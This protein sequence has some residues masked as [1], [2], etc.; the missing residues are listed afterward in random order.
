M[1]SG[2]L[3]ESIPK[4]FN[5]IRLDEFWK[6][7]CER[8][9]IWERRFVEK[10]KPPWTKDTVLSTQRFT[11][12]Y[13]EL[14]PGTK[15]A[16][17][18]ILEIDAPKADKIF[19]I[20]IYRLIGRSETHK[21]LGFQHLDDFN[22]KSMEKS[23]FDIK[24]RGQPPFTAAYMVS[25]YSMMGSKDKI[26]NVTRIFSRLRDRFPGFY[27]KLINT[28]SSEEAYKIIKE[29]DGFGN[30]LAYQVLV[31]LIYPLR[32]YDNKPILPFSN[33]DWAI[34]G[35]GAR[36][37][38]KLLINAPSKI[39]EL[40]VMRW[41]CQNQSSEFERLGIA[42]PYLK[43]KSGKPVKISLANI[44]N[45]LCEFHKYIKIRDGTGRGRRLFSPSSSI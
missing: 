31:D 4:S 19:N 33:D 12:V 23:L 17:E 8:Q 40:D 36:K 2:P 5:K 16:I 37:G 11:N 29:N 42:F 15:Y 22:P 27:K 34:A 32:A 30:F 41:L 9:S 44:Q 25:G 10:L 35:P 1:D 14:D 24:L 7:L 13:R 39:N 3:S 43:D 21:E 18:A 20:M 45:C 38:I 6:F 28:K 26:I